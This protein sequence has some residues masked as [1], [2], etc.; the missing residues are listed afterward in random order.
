MREYINIYQLDDIGDKTRLDDYLVVSQNAL[1]YKI[2]MG[3]LRNFIIEDIDYGDAI[4]NSNK[5]LGF[6]IEFTEPV[7]NNQVLTFDGSMDAWTNKEIDI[8]VIFSDPD[9]EPSKFLRLDSQSN[10]ITSDV[11]VS[12]LVVDTPDKGDTFLGVANNG[13]DVIYVDMYGYINNTI[14]NRT[15]TFLPLLNDEIARAIAEEQRLQDEIDAEIARATSEEARIESKFDNLIAVE[16]S[17]IEGSTENVRNELTTIINAESDRAKAEEERIES[18]IIV[19]RDRAKAEEERIE[20]KFDNLIDDTVTAIQADITELDNRLTTGLQNEI[21][22]ATAEELRLDGEIDVV[23]SRLDVEIARAIE[24]ERRLEQM[25]LNT[26]QYSEDE[27]ARLEA[28]IDTE[29]DRATSEEQ[30]IEDLINNEII[31]STNEDERLETLIGNLGDIEAT[32]DTLVLRDENG[33]SKFS[34]PTHDQHP[35]R[36]GDTSTESIPGTVVVRDENGNMFTTGDG[37][38]GIGSDADPL[39]VQLSSRNGNLLQLGTDGIYYGIEPPSDVS[40]LYVAASGND[41]NSGTKESPLRT[42]EEAFR[43][44]PISSSSTIHIK[45]GETH[46]IERSTERFFISG[47]VRTI[48]PYDDPYIDGNMVPELSPTVWF[49]NKWS[50]DEINRPIINFNWEY[51]EYN[52]SAAVAKI[53]MVAGGTM[54]F[55]GCRLRRGV[56]PTANSYADT[57]IIGAPTQYNGTAEF[58]GCEIE[59]RVTEPTLSQETMF[60]VRGDT[61]SLT[62]TFNSTKIVP[63]TN[64]IIGAADSVMTLVVSKG[65][66][67]APV[68]IPGFTRFEDN[69]QDNAYNHVTGLNKVNGVPVNLLTNLTNL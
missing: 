45:A 57:A 14:D 35:I 66:S 47:A 59:D 12:D 41:S 40:N 64:L 13:S 56:Q 11:F 52:D 65:Q 29:I 17:N 42:I 36:R 50:V 21:D 54:R 61:G 15:G 26:L 19:E 67:Y 30:R 34:E 53:I 43:R 39:K 22:R 4:Y 8:N 68:E 16:I 1:S 58:F 23:D 69:F 6:D 33:T 62:F 3:E 9:Y 2:R 7:S 18:L 28:K 60:R 49:Y 46:N 55:N 38:E 27:I 48:Q 44:I 24:E 10:V 31:R 5:L 63:G 51:R 37:L 32:P 25:I 20:N